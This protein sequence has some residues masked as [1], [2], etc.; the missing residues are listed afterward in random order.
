MQAN[1]FEKIEEMVKDY[2]DSCSLLLDFQNELNDI[3][4]T[5]KTHRKNDV[6]VRGKNEQI[7][8]LNERRN[9]LKDDIASLKKKIKALYSE[10]E[11]LIFSSIKTSYNEM[12]EKQLSRLYG[13]KV[14]VLVKEP[15]DF[16]DEE[17]CIA[18]TII[19]TKN[20]KQHKK[21]VKMLDFGIRDKRNYYTEKKVKV[22][23]CI[24]S[25]KHLAGETLPYD[26][27][28]LK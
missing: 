10:T 21:I 5:L 8:S 18:T 25:K 23:V 27:E 16:Y 26:R 19:V 13:Y 15:G 20:K 28:L 17:T 2:K 11:A 3:S 9:K 6:A 24:Y 14:D 4:N 22:E 1:N 12:Y 7:I